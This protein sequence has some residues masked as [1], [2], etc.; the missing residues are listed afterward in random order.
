MLEPSVMV[1][2]TQS[3]FQSVFSGVSSFGKLQLRKGGAGMNK[4]LKR[5]GWRGGP[6]GEEGGIMNAGDSV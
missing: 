5:I 6:L 2:K 4:S 3:G 1:A